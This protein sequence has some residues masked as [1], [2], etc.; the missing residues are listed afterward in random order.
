M[1][2]SF[3]AELWEWGARPGGWHF[4]TLPVDVADELREQSGPPAGFGSIQVVA[5][6][7]ATTWET[8]VFPESGG[9][10]FVLPVKKGVRLAEGVEAGDACDLTV[11]PATQSVEPV[12]S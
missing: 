2:A 12:E 4:V 7:G 11:G 3:T 1:T 5:T 8:S 9:E 6:L 10:S